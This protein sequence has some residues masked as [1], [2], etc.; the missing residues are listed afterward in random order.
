MPAA[1][2]EADAHL[3]LANRLALPFARRVFLAYPLRGPQRAALP[4]RRA[5]DPGAVARTIPQAEARE[6]FELPAE[7]PVLLVA[8]ALAGAR[9][10]N[11]I[12]I[13]AFGEVG[14]ADP[15]HLRRARLLVA[16]TSRAA[17]RRLPADPLDRPD[18]RGLLGRRPRRSRAPAA[19]SGRSR[20]PA[21]RRSSSPTRSRPATTRRRTPSYFVQRGRRDD[22]PR[23]RPR[24]RARPR[25]LAARRPGRGSQRMGEAMLR[26]AQAGRGRGDR[27]GADRACPPLEGRRLWFV[28]IGGAGLSA[29]AQLAR[30]WGAEVGGWDR[31]A[32]AVPRAA[33]RESRSR[34]RPSRVVPGGLGGRRLVRL[35]GRARPLARGVPRRARRAAPLDR[36]RR[37]ARE[38]DDRGDDRLRARARPAATRP[39]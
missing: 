37:H 33:R 32:H 21:S 24:R 36:R 13:E 5:A 1:L 7:G 22:D 29:Y 25:P 34:S 4:R 18:R 26:V 15:P 17:A 19:R 27:R 9:S 28:G 16:P 20:R 8:G 10:I 31:V 14:P 11:E 30:A 38:G 39:G 3:G 6:I 2:S 23:P 12:V 35:P